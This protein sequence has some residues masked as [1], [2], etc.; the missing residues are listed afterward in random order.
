MWLSLTVPSNNIVD[1]NGDGS[2]RV[3]GNGTS[4][5]NNNSS[6]NGSGRSSYLL[7]TLKRIL[8]ST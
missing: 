7:L 5:N 8:A 4:D 2:D 3:S 1:C 6:N